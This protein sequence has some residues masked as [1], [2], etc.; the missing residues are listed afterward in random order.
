MAKLTFLSTQTIAEFKQSNGLTDVDILLYE[1]GTCSFET[2]NPKLSGKGSKPA[3]EAYDAGK[4]DT[5]RI[6]HVQDELLLDTFYLLHVG[7]D[8]QTVKRG[9][10]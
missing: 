3:R 7:G 9:K 2:S 6:S 8:E 4:T 5:L 1:S 10:L